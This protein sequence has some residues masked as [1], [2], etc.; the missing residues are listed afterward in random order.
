MESRH[1]SQVVEC[2]R[3]EQANAVQLY[4]QYKGYHWNVRGPQFH[5]LHLMFDEH[6]KLVLDTVDLLA[7]RQ[8]ILGAPAHYDLDALSRSSQLAVDAHLPVTGHEMVEHLVESHRHIIRN[9]K[10]GFE[11]STELH[12]PGTAD[13]VTR[14]LVVHE[15]LEWFLREL[16]ERRPEV[17]EA[18]PVGPTGVR[19]HATIPTGVA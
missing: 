7:E 17:V 2:L 9:F 18:L 8:R 15:K 10:A 12:D 3:H 4:L 6:A 19:G 5:D 16:L 14:C 11:L 1:P 13:L